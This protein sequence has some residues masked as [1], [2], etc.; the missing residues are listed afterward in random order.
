MCT[1][2]LLPTRNG[3]FFTLWLTGYT[4]LFPRTLSP[5]E[6][7]DCLEG[8]AKGDEKAWG[9]LSNIAYGWWRISSRRGEAEGDSLRVKSAPT[10]V[11][12]F[13]M[14]L[15]VKFLF[16]SAFFDHDLF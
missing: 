8:M 11:A 14:D 12:E 1:A 15:Q 9:C 4:G 10:G 3:L 6:E 2:W 13:Q 5:E 7:Q 16:G